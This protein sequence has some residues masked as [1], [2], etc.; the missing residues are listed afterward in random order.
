RSALPLSV[1]EG[2]NPKPRLSLVAPAMLG[3][4]TTNDILEIELAARL[5]EADIVAALA[6]VV[7][8]GLQIREAR[9]LDTIHSKL[10]SRI[11]A[12]HYRC[13]KPVPGQTASG[14]D[15][16]VYRVDSGTKLKDALQAHWGCDIL[17]LLASDLVRDG[18]FVEQAGEL[19]DAFGV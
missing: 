16:F 2:F 19:V 13:D 9:H 5:P 15:G 11:V 10:V 7:P 18:L 3:M 1:S 8:A 4:A 6:G 14:D 17:D 12:H